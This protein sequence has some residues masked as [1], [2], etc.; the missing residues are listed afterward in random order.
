MSF[1]NRAGA[2]APVDVGAVLD[3]GAVEYL[4]SIVQAGAL[5]SLGRTRDG[6]TMSITVTVDGAYE[7]EW[8]RTAEEACDFLRECDTFLQGAPQPPPSKP[9]PRK[10][11]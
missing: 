10:A 11:A 2:R 6:G 9:R 8:V 5:V 7:R 3:A 1:L 4:A